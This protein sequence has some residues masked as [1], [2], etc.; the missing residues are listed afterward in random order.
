MTKSSLSGKTA[1]VTGATQGIGLAAAEAFARMGARVIITARSAE[2]GEA[3]KQA[4]K[5]AGG[6]DEVEVVDVDFASMASMR[7]GAAAVRELTDR[8]HILLNNVGAVFMERQL[9]K[10]G[11]ELTFATNHLGYFLWTHELLDLVKG[12]APARIV[13]VSSSA[14]RAVR[15]VD[16]DDL[17]RRRSYSGF[18]VYAES[19]LM[20]ILFTRELARRLEGSGVTVNCLHPGVIASGFG[21]NNTGV[22]GFVTRHL[23]PIFLTSPQKGARTSIWACTAPELAGTTGRY[24]SLC[25][26]A[27]PTKAATDMAA[28]ARLWELSE[29]I[30]GIRPSVSAA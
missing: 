15:G 14:H 12:A 22:L 23:S 7:S 16:F 5:R 21:T 3:A 2:R 19:K 17:Q 27:K 30:C 8:I 25:K 28:A 10:D 6:H 18:P 26:E 4:I 29:E 1:V 11:L 13:N 20:N 24:F 9:S